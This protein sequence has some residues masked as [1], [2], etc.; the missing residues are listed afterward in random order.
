[1]TYHT[2]RWLKAEISRLEAEVE[3][4][5]AARHRTEA[6]RINL[7][8]RLLRAEHDFPLRRRELCE[9]LVG[10]ARAFSPGDIRAPV[11]P[12]EQAES[13]VRRIIA[14]IDQV[15]PNYGLAVGQGE[16]NEDVPR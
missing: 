16:N 11:I 10:V 1:V 6:W 14:A 13:E 8:D 12:R 15:Q 4:Q 5:I 2:R 3:E 9:E 7:R